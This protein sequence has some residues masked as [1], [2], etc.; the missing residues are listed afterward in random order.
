MDDSSSSGSSTSWVT[1][2]SHIPNYLTCV[3]SSNPPKREE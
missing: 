1:Y 2:L 3:K